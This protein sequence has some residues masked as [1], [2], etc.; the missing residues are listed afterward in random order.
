MFDFYSRCFTNF[1]CFNLTHLLREC[2]GCHAGDSSDRPEIE[3]VCR[4]RSWLTFHG[5]YVLWQSQYEFATFN[6]ICWDKVCESGVPPCPRIK[7]TCR[8]YRR[9]WFLSLKPTLRFTH[10]I[11]PSPNLFFFCVFTVVW[12]PAFWKWCLDRWIGIQMV[13]RRYLNVRHNDGASKQPVIWQAAIRAHDGLPVPYK[14]MDC[15]RR[16]NGWYLAGE[17][18]NAVGFHQS[19]KFGQWKTISQPGEKK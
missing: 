11:G 9:P 7:L 19:S 8:G 10:L 16:T 15:P 5:I 14:E 18:G 12:Q 1:P 4:R 3:S 6:A 17:H 2:S 13:A